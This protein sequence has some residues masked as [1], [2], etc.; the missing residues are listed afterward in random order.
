MS[1]EPR[2]GN[3]TAS[4]ADTAALQALHESQH[5]L[6]TLLGNPPGMVYRCRYDPEWPFE[7]VS[8]GCLDPTDPV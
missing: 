8:Q 1:D 4:G 6:L 2:R 5:M 7:F 3:R